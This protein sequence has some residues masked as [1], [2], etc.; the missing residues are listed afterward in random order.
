MIKQ[1]RDGHFIIAKDT[2]HNKVVASMSL[3][4]SNTI[5]LKYVMKNF[6]K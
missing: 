4:V 6:K 5:A 1:D 2:A 3:H